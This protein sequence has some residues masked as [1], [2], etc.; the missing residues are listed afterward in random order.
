[1]LNL[2]IKFP[3]LLDN[4]DNKVEKDYSSWPDRLYVVGQDGK[5]AYKGGPGPAGFDSA[6]L[7]VF[8]EL[9]LPRGAGK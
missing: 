7:G 5:V 8:L 1:V 4:M 6:E 3:T 9:I 2:G